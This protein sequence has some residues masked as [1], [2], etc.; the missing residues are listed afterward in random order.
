VKFKDIISGIFKSYDLNRIAS[1]HVIDFK[2]L[3]EDELR[4]ALLKFKPQYVDQESVEAALDYAFYG[5]PDPIIRSLSRVIMIDILLNQD[6]FH[7]VQKETYE[8][9]IEFLQMIV[10][11]SNELNLIDFTNGIKDCGHHRELDLYNFV[12]QTAWE[13]NVQS[14][15]EVNLLRKLRIRLH[16]NEY[17]HRILESKMGKYPNLDNEL[18]NRNEMENAR[19]YLQTKGLLFSYRDGENNDYDVIPDEIAQIIRDIHSIEMKDYNFQKM[20]D[21]KSLK[22]RNFLIK[23]LQENNIE[24][25]KND[26]IGKL[27]E[28]L[29]RNVKP[30]SVLGGVS[31]YGGLSDDALYKWC[32]DL[33]IMVSGTKQEKIDRII[34]HYESILRGSEPGPDEREKWY[35]HYE[36]F[37]SRDRDFLRAQHLIDKDLEIEHRFEDATSF[38]FEKKLNHTP[39][40]RPGSKRPDGILSFK[41]MYLMWDNKSKDPNKPVNRKEHIRQFDEYMDASDKRVPI[42]LVIGPEFTEESETDAIQYTA[43][44]IDRNVVLV[45]AEDLKSLAEEWS[46]EKNKKKDEPFP[47]GLLKRT[48]KFERALLGKK[49]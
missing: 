6:G 49:L 41:D 39:L 27:Q 42:F 18:F 48:G 15:D 7:L 46:S 24:F 21:Y 10:D 4:N 2:G 23:V 32:N 45:R 20:L 13:D 34:D 12:L 17:E 26:N 14:P 29:I 16:I 1:A 31:T 5:N 47:L 11:R 22:K 3:D 37:A 9:T 8:K 43:K 28:K 25:R 36:K 35:S 30:S 44:N 19:K 40:K 38:L 33:G